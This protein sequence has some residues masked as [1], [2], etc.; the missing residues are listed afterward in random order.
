M[1][2]LSTQ[3]CQGRGEGGRALCPAGVWPRNKVHLLP[4]FWEAFYGTRENK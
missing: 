4:G 3:P 2:V 1:V